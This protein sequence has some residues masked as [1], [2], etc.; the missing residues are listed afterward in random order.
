MTQTQPKPKLAAR[1][2]PDDRSR[3]E[4]LNSV[5]QA[6]RGLTPEKPQTSY[7]TP[8]L[9]QCTLPHSDPETPTWVK[10]NGD[11][12]LKVTSGIDKEGNFYGIPYGAF[13][14]LVLAYIITAIKETG[15]LRIELAAGFTA[16][17]KEIGYTGNLRGDTRASRAMQR[18]LI[19]L[20]NSNIAFERSAGNA[21]QG[22]I[23]SGRLDVAD[24]IALWWDYKNPDQ[25]SLWGSYIEVSEKF[26]QAILANPLPL[27]RDIIAALRKSA[28]ALDV[29]MWV[30]YRLFTLQ[31][32]GQEQVS[33][34]YGKL[35]EQ[36]GT[37]ISEANYRSFRRDFKNALGKVAKYWRSPDGEKELL[38]YELREDGF[39]LFRSPL[40]IG[41]PKR[42]IAEQAA[43]EEA[44]RIISTRKFDEIT[45][46]QAR[47]IAGSQWDVRWLANQ[48]FD[49][50]QQK[51]SAPKDPRAHFLA[52]IKSHRERNE[53]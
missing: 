6:L 36:F 15:A 16:F 25:D 2:H 33:L 26:R 4:A 28:L 30:S 24:T 21:E 35:Q 20:L 23:I 39:T 51:G 27:R 32:T 8:F 50:V 38:N 31:N 46:K 40:L 41:I 45:M 18:N 11:F 53:K 3:I 42:K 29:Y 14:R 12:T 10:T 44:Q 13:P 34:S 19:R 1:T 48:Y 47:Q 52:F 37:G 49:W 43:E 9:I 5:G 17:L 22:S 7:Y